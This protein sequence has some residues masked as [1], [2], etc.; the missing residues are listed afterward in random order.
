MFLVCVGRAILTCPLLGLT[1]NTSHPPDRGDGSASRPGCPFVAQ[2]AR[3]TGHG[4]RD[5]HERARRRDGEAAFATACLQSR[6]RGCRYIFRNICSST[7]ETF[8]LQSAFG[9][10]VHRGDDGDT[11]TVRRGRG[12][13][14]SRADD[15]RERGSTRRHRS[16]ISGGGLRGVPVVSGDSTTADRRRTTDRRRVRRRSRR[17]RVCRGVGGESI[18]IEPRYSTSLRTRSRRDQTTRVGDVRPE[19]GSGR[20]P[21]GHV[22]GVSVPA[23]NRKPRS[24]DGLRAREREAVRVI[25]YKNRWRIPQI[26]RELTEVRSRAV[27]ST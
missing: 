13:T 19:A 23:A 3:A 21:A 22:F 15:E 14:G 10:S 20:R 6:E 5:R 8:T 11:P 26:V 12:T 1:L 4:R 7:N 2:P 18:A 25:N 24:P 9:R 17:D 27:C 16:S